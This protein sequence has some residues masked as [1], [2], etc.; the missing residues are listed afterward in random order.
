MPTTKEGG[1]VTI[2]YISGVTVGSPHTELH[3]AE[4][5][6]GEEGGREG[7]RGV[8]KSWTYWMVLLELI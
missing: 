8:I 4:E 5:R 3:A 2:D 6:A 1:G 7:G